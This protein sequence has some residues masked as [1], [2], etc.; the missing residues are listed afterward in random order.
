MITTPLQTGSD[1]GTDA[2]LNQCPGHSHYPI[3]L[4]K[5]PITS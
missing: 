2:Y 4:L 1:V 5:S 3:Q